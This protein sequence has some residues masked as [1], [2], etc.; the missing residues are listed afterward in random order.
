MTDDGMLYE[1][2]TEFGHYGV[3]DTIYNGRKARVL[4]SGSHD[5]AQSGMALDGKAEL[6]FDYNECFMELARGMRPK[7]VLVLGGGAFTF[8]TALR[9]EF[10]EMRIDVVELD[11]GLVE[12]GRRYFDFAPNGHTTLYIGDGAQFIAETSKQ[13]DLIVVDVFLHATIPTSFQTIDTVQNFYKCLHKDGVVAINVIASLAGIRS[14]VLYRL[15]EVLRTTFPKVRAYPATR[16]LASWTPQNFIV[17]AQD[18]VHDI[19]SYLRR[20]PVESLVDE[21]PL[22]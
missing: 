2:D 21:G 13:Y 4:Y 8:P 16:A 6:L 15:Y 9:R 14:A 5:A 1:C 10:P 7:H 3:A 18:G 19:G 22:K 11:G 20:S 12:I 17:T